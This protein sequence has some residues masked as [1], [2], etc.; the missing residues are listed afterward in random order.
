MKQFAAHKTIKIKK[1]IKAPLPKV[2]SAFASSRARSEWAVPKGDAIK[3]TRTDF[4]AGGVDNFRCGTPKVL[5]FRGVVTY[6]E[7][8]KNMKIISTENIY[9]S[10]GI[11]S[12]TLITTEL[13]RSAT[14]TNVV[15]T[16]QICSLNGNDMSKGYKD[17]WTAVLK[18]LE[19]YLLK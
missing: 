19:E 8:V 14:G 7:I 17:G 18:N 16:A 4:R 5:E 9:H 12:V 11:L 3:Y 10:R 13:F 2:Y 15:I 1:K 6:H